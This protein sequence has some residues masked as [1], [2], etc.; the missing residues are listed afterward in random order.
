MDFA[1]ILTGILWVAAVVI[2]YRAPRRP[3]VL[4]TVMML[5]GLGSLN[6]A[7]YLHGFD[8]WAWY[9]ECRS[10][11]L[12][13]FAP[14]ATGLLVGV[15]AARCGDRRWWPALV[16]MAVASLYAQM[17]PWAKP[18]LD[19]LQVPLGARQVVRNGV[20]LQ[21]TGSTCGPC[22]LAVVLDRQG[23]VASE[24]DLARACYTSASGTELWYLAREARR[25]GATARFQSGG[26]FVA[27][28]IIGIRIVQTGHFVAVLGVDGERIHLHD[29]LSGL[30]ET[31]EQELRV[32][33]RFGGMALII[34]D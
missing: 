2:G 12:T 17:L 31:T 14:A 34:G 22:A 1:L 3:W 11:P 5:F 20:I 6:A 10:W 8:T 26:P 19:P 4:L 24:G 28:S 21:S 18:L 29:S 30:R 23:I 9:H 33:H 7:Y 15:I 32:R 27:G 13:D 16:L 25:R